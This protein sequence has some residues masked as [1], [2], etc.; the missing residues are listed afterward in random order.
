M[1][2]CHPEERFHVVVRIG[3]IDYRFGRRSEAAL[4][5]EVL[6]KKGSLSNVHQIRSGV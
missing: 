5:A 4:I 2:A 1:L 6:I 3:K